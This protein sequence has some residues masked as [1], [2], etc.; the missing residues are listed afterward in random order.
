MKKIFYG[1]CAVWALIVF[2]VLM[3]LFIPAF[4]FTDIYK[5]PTKSKNFLLVSRVW[6][7]LFIYLT[8]SSLK[9]N[10]KENFL[11]GETYIVTYN[12]NS[13]LDVPISCPFTPGPNKTIGKIEMMK[14]PIFNIPYKRGAVLIDRKS[15]T[16]RFNA[17]SAMQSVIAGGMHMCVY[18][19]GTRN[20]TNEPLMPFKAG[21]FKLAIET[22]K[23]IIPA[24]ITGTRKAY[25][26]GA[27]MWYKPGKFTLTFYP[28]ISPVGKTEESLMKEVFDVMY[29]KYTNT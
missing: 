15:K 9:V 16:S 23:S 29:N 25:P 8:G 27:G 11:K 7:W 18:P 21:A 6:N 26:S 22:G 5:E 28:A 24:I 20:K 2:A 14:I 12:H 17:Y 13:F 10:G 1:A 3:L 19:E 4:L